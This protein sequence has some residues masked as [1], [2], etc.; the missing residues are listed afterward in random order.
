MPI[1]PCPVCGDDQPIHVV[2][3]SCDSEEDYYLCP[4]CG[5]TWTVRKK[6]TWRATQRTALQPLKPIRSQRG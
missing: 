2:D 5:Q 3:A 6:R 4:S 1:L